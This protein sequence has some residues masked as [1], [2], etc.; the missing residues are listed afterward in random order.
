M[1]TKQAKRRQTI[2]LRAVI[3]LSLAAIISVG[4]SCREHPILIKW[5]EGEASCIGKPIYA[6]VYTDGQDCNTIKVYR[7]NRLINDYLIALSEPDRYGMLKYININLDKKWIG[8]SV[9]TDN[10]DYD[11]V[12]GSLYQSEV[13]AHF[14][15]FR[16]DIKGFNFNP[17]LYHSGDTIKFNM[18]Q[19][20]LKFNA[21][22]IVL[23][24]K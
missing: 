16:D 21:L 19:G 7:N 14:V 9:A 8:R 15:D 1:M 24:S 13:G 18:P 22:T 2:I 11:I 5:L 4:I 6:K 23:P 10:K 20:Y 17:Y 12:N 3:M